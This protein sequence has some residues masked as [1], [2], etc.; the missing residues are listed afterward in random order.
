M[1]SSYIRER[2]RKGER[3][4]GKEKK[5]EERKR[6]LLFLRKREIRKGKKKIKGERGGE[7]RGGREEEDMKRFIFLPLHT[8]RKR[9]NREKIGKRI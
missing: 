7:E 5:R 9:K 3:S 2:G 4:K 8:E 1:I 6:V